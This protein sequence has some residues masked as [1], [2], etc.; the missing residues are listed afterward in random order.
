MVQPTL[1]DEEA[2]ERLGGFS[3]LPVPSRKRYLRLTVRF[4]VG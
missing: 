3:V 4:L 2:N 1:K